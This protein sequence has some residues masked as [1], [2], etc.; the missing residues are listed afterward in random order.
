MSIQTDTSVLDN[1]YTGE[2]LTI[3]TLKEARNGVSIERCLLWK[4]QRLLFSGIS[5]LELTENYKQADQ[6]W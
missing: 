2:S 1:I 6:I 4:L 3:K 5:L